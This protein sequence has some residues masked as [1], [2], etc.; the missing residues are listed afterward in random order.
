MRPQYFPPVAQM[1][2]WLP[3]HK[4]SGLSLVSRI[5]PSHF[6]W[7]SPGTR[8]ATSENLQLFKRCWDVITES[9]T[10]ELRFCQILFYIF[11]HTSYHK[12]WYPYPYVSLFFS[13]KSSI[14]F[15]FWAPW[16][17]KARYSLRSR[18]LC[19]RPPWL[20]CAPNQNRH[21][22]QAKHDSARGARGGGKREP[23]RAR[24]VPLPLP[25]WANFTTAINDKQH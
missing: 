23:P 21:L 24:K 15:Q 8:L 10:A 1:W 18:F 14:V 12:I 11:I 5:F 7:K 4:L 3:G 25:P 9:T 2:N 16:I 20:V 19:P 13:R 22:T 6:P 17:E